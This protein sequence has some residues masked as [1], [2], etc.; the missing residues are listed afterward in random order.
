MGASSDGRGEYMVLSRLDEERRDKLGCC[1]RLILADL[2]EFVDARFCRPGVDR[3]R[4]SRSEAVLGVLRRTP[5]DEAGLVEET[6][7]TRDEARLGERWSGVGEDAG[8]GL[9][10]RADVRDRW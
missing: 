8:N 9:T 4:S 5:L 7:R 3:R 10:E 1:S 2:R 6:L